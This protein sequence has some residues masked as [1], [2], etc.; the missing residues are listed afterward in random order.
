MLKP[1]FEWKEELA[2]CPIPDDLEVSVGRGGAPTLRAGKVYL[3][4]RYNPEQEAERLVDSAGLDPARPVLVLGLGLGYHV[5]A[6][7][8]RGFDVVVVEP[9]P[10]V[11]RL[12][13][14][15]PMAGSTLPLGVGDAEELA[16]TE[17][18]GELARRMPQILIHPPTAKLHP[19]YAESLP[20]LL[21]KAALAGQHLSI[22]VVGPVYGGSLPIAGYLASALRGLGHRVLDVDNRAGHALYTSVQE[23]VTGSTPQAQL[24]QMLTNV[25]SEW[26]YARVAEF[27]PEV[28]IVLAQA[29]VGPAFPLRLAEKGIVSAYWYVENWRHM[30]Y[31]RDIAAQYD[32][33]FH[34]QPGEFEQQLDAIGCRHHAFVQTGCDPD[35]HRPVELT[36]EERKHYG[37]DVS[38]AGAG[39][40]NRLNVFK[41]LTDYNFKIWG[42]NWQ[43]RELAR[44][45]VG[46]E[47]FFSTEEY[48]K[49][50]A[51]SKINLNLHSS[52]HHDGVD[53]TCD[54]INPRVFEVAAAGGF[55]ICDPCVGLDRLYDFETEMPIYRDLA[56]C[57]KLLDYYLAHPGEREAMARRA[58][59]RALKDHTYE[60]RA[61]QMLDLIFEHHGARILK[62][63][64]RVQHT[65]E[66]VSYTHL[67]LPTN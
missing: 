51:G 24:T 28:C 23:S 26:S 21:A 17:A 36:E 20:G 18:F 50:V 1:I 25:L 54:A 49:I 2:A 15:G 61:K 58:R 6:L 59:E 48:M 7:A 19:A 67:T 34:I 64:V 22:A 57:R 31:W 52:S 5:R 16:A 47:K 8:D 66:A 60:N 46:G 37:C 3:H 38:F 29:P 10:A 39:Y 27:N 65:V 33:F 45:V 11:A 4:S 43:S 9:D 35:V 55:Q 30:P 12:A 41:G 63:G 53:P 44:N 42:V 56:G 40:Y 62:R 32:Y 14:E 13:G